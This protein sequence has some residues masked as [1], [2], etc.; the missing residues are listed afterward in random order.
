[1]ATRTGHLTDRDL[2]ILTTLTTKVRVL[3][4]AQVARVWWPLCDDPDAAARQRVAVLRRRGLVAVAEMAVHP[5]LVLDAPLVAW[6][7]GAEAPQL[8]AIAYRLESRW[9]LPQRRTA[10]VFATG[11]AAARL[12]GE[13]G[14]APRAQE[15]SHDVSLAA[16]YLRLRDVEPERAQTWT[17]EA[18]LVRDGWGQCTPLPDALTYRQDTT[19]L[20][21]FAGHYKKAKLVHFHQF[22]SIARYAYEVW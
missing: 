8:G 16:L 20:I 19:V 13:P 22:C 2:D 9:S 12:G 4:L 1:M 3:S 21:E 15:A 14:R 5:E 11:R 6:V 10:L 17:S 18:A 7:P